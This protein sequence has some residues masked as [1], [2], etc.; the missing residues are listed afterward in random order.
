MKTSWKLALVTV[1]FVLA[2]WLSGN[3]PAQ[4]LPG[5][6]CDNYADKGP[7]HFGFRFSCTWANGAQ[8][9]CVCDGPTWDCV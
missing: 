3:R 6:V 5:Q 4:A 1:I 9:F 7:C 2:A 8:G